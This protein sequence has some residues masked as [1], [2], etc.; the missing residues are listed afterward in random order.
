M[1]IYTALWTK[2]LEQLQKPEALNHSVVGAVS[3][4]CFYSS[5]DPRRNEKCIQLNSKSKLFLSWKRIIIKKWGSKP[6]WLPHNGRGCFCIQQWRKVIVCHRSFNGEPLKRQVRSS[7]CN[8][9]T[10][11]TPTCDISFSSHRLM[12]FPE[13]LPV[14]ILFQAAH[15]LISLPVS[16]LSSPA[17]MS[18]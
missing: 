6:L 11:S 4:S 18:D 15:I 5:L 1:N 16:F 17:E 13:G 3:L 7:T 12:N 10:S 2:R 8:S 9:R 14:S